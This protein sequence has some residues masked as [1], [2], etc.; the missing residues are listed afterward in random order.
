MKRKKKHFIIH[1]DKEEVVIG[2]GN[3]DDLEVLS[4]RIKTPMNITDEED[5]R[6]SITKKLSKNV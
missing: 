3:V 5:A 4:P 6:W 1:N 2:D